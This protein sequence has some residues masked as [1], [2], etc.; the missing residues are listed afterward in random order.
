M[1][2]FIFF[3]FLIVLVGCRKEYNQ[4]DF[5]NSI[6]VSQEGSVISFYGDKTFLVKNLK[7][8]FFYSGWMD[9]LCNQNPST[10][11]GHWQVIDTSMGY[12]RIECYF[13]SNSF[14]FDIVNINEIRTAIGDPDDGIYYIF[15][16]K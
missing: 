3:S 8:V 4:N 14:N 11:R 13:H 10:F 12:Q 15:H 6:W 16:R 1:M 9:S 2:R 5:T 7:W